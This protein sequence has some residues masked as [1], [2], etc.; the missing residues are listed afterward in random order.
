[1]AKKRNKRVYFRILLRFFCVAYTA[2]RKSEKQLIYEIR[3]K[4]KFYKHKIMHIYA[5]IKVTLFQEAKKTLTEQGWQGFFYG[6]ENRLGMK[7][8]TFAEKRPLLR[9]KQK[10]K[11]FYDIVMTDETEELHRNCGS[12]KSRKN[13]DP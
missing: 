1:M 3:Q 5:F 4:D 10:R 11:T 7:M 12:V 8:T 2:Y 6:H 13:I 9:K